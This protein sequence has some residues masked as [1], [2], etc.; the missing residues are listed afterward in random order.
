ML[1]CDRALQAS[2]L[3]WEQD[4][5]PVLSDY[6]R[7]PNLSQIF[8]PDWKKNGA[9]DKA[10]QLFQDWLQKNKASPYLHSEIVQFPGKTPVLLIE[11]PG[12]AGGNVLIYGHLDKQPPF[13][14]WRAGLDPWKPTREG[15]R[16]YGRGAADDGYAVFAAVGAL[17][18]LAEQNQPRPR[19]IILIEAGEESGSPD[20]PFYLEY[21]APKIGKPQLIVCLDSGCASYDRLWLTTSLRGLITGTLRAD[22]L[23]EGVHSGDSSGIVPSSS[24]VLRQVIAR[25]EDPQSGSVTLKELHAEIPEER[26]RQARLLATTVGEDLIRHFP[27]VEENDG[28]ILN[29]SELVLN[30]TWR[31]TLCTIG[32][33]GLPPLS[34][35]GNVLRPYTAEKLSIRLPPTVNAFE[36]A[37]ALKHRL[38]ER[39]PWKSRVAFR[40]EK[41]ATGW[42]APPLAHWLVES[43]NESSLAFFGRTM[44]QFGEGATIPFAGLLAKEFRDA[45]FLVTGVLGPESNAHGPNEFLHL[46]TAKRLTACLAK[47]LND[48]ALHYS[49]R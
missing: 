32:G 4:A 44:M 26:R 25:V 49:Q 1:Q 13:T 28:G 37:A 17:K 48:F 21:L 9:M 2:E 24:T 39:P 3:F 47:T 6:L 35:A 30:R 15:D 16:L 29:L 41:V 12:T 7:L 23:T 45:Q 18:L 27:F 36:A 34:A 11:I 42:H 14:G 33:E 20:L 31:P 43:L 46:P 5:L 22:V 38:E 8:D 40:V 19:C 10:A